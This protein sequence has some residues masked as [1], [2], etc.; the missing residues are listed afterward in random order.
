V[1]ETPDGVIADGEHLSNVSFCL[2][3][4]HHRYRFLKAWQGRADTAEK[5]AVFVLT[6]NAGAVSV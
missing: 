4:G 3:E 1:I 5:H 2:I 6:M